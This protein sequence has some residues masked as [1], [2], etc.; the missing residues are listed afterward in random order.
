MNG[1]RVPIYGDNY[2]KGHPE[3][4]VVDRE[5]YATVLK[6][7]TNAMMNFSGD[8]FMIFA[9][10]KNM[11]TVQFPDWVNN[12]DGTANPDKYA[13]M[14]CDYLKFMKNEGFEVDVLGVD[15]EF[16][17]NSGKITVDKYNKIV[18]L[19]K[20]YCE[21]NGIKVPQFVA[22]DRYMPQG[23]KPEAWLNT[24]K[25]KNALIR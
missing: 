2:Y 22:H 14:L 4:G 13:I 3:L 21:E 6:S 23:D 12:E 17:Y 8:K 7:M 20:K 18:P 24:A 25:K 10:K 19:V 16:E 5:A 11:G 9:S 1:L 15:N